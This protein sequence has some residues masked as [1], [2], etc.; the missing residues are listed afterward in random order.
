MIC[1]SSQNSGVVLNSIV[2]NE[3]I[4][5]YRFENGGLASKAR[6]NR[7][8]FNILNE[9]EV[10][11][12]AIFLISNQD[13]VAHKGLHKSNRLSLFPSSPSSSLLEFNILVAGC[14]ASARD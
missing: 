10:T 4:G 6:L 8:G 12:Q 1:T 2:I 5:A 3:W 9:N 13:T 11:K 14:V 7:R